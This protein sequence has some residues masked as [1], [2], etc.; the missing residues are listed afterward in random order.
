MRFWKYHGLGNDFI[1]LEDD[2]S[3][4]KDPKT[5]RSLC[6]RRFGIGADG[7]LYLG[8]SQSA[9][10]SM[11][12]MNS[13]GSE[14]EM[15]GN[16]IRCLAKHLHGRVGKERLT[17]DTKAGQMTVTCHLDNG[18]VVEVEVDMG[19]PILDC[20]RIPMDCRGRF[21]AKDIEV[22]GR[23]L[24]GTAVSMGNPHFVTFEELSEGEMRRLGPMI[25]G[26]P[27]FPRRTN[28][29]FVSVHHGGLR[30][31]V[32]ER[33]AGWT[34]AC[35]TGACAAT[36]AAALSG[37]VPFDREIRVTLPGGDLR[38][39]VPEDLSSVLMTGPVERVYEGY[40]GDQHGI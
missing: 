6:Q 36:V 40:I 3:V 30:V 16:G 25:E 28:V 8:T 1:L 38:V 5:V 29:E 31:E 26:H 13:D 22:D 23:R 37:L 11:R 15:C 20:E 17:I 10:A 32:Y 39:R 14:A 21:V 35:G 12:I 18:E 33:G 34:L 19:P 24:K 9:D 4:P 2:G 27:S 7:T